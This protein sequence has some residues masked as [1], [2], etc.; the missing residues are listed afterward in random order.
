MFGFF[1][2]KI[3]AKREDFNLIV[4]D[5]QKNISQVHTIFGNEIIEIIN[6][7]PPEDKFGSQTFFAIP[8][9]EAIFGYQITCLIGFTSREGLISIMDNLELKELLLTE[10]SNETG[11]DKNSIKGYDNLFLSCSGN[12]E[13]LNNEFFNLVCKICSIDKNSTSAP[14]IKKKLENKSTILAIETQKNT[15]LAFGSN[16]LVN[17]LDKVLNKNSNN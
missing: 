17:Q 13:C 6:K 4:K 15:A 2:K 12:I 5:L 9:Y 10:I 1:K 8:L 14:E 11:L 7:I 3:K 16:D